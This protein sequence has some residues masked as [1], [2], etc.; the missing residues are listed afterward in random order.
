MF[1]SI[2]RCLR[3]HHRQG[4][5][6]MEAMVAI[7]VM[8]IAGSA[9]L[10]G[11]SGAMQT[12]DD[13]LQHALAL[14]MAQ[15]LMDEILGQRYHAVGSDGYELSM[16]ASSWEYSGTG[17]ERFNDIDDY[18]RLRTSP[19]IE[20]CGT[21]IGTGDDRGGLRHPNF[22]V[23]HDYFRNWRQ[24]IDI[25]YVDPDDFTRNLPAGT[26]SDYR[27]VVVRIVRQDPDRDPRV[28]A[29]LRQVVAYVPP[30]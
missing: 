10:W 26:P 19:P 22:R 28:L 11:V 18:N 23:A 2:G 3:P 12:T 1:S 7:T 15:Q 9:L 29:Q 27:A 4:F 17:R 25:F 24:E 5:T 21:A 30:L 8:A 13:N 6:L 14:G 20:L 16:G